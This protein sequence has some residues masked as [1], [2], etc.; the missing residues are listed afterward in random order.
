[1][2]SILLPDLGGGGAERIVVNL[3]NTWS[4]WGYKTEIVLMQHGGEFS[5]TVNPSVSVYCLNCPR[6]RTVPW[7]L[8]RYLMERRPNVLLANMWPLTSTAVLAWYLAGRRGK[9]FLCDHIALSEHV[10]RDLRVPLL[11]V[12]ALLRLSYPKA[13]GLIVVSKGVARD[14]ATISGLPEKSFK[15]IYNPVVEEG[16]H[17]YLHYQKSSAIQFLLWGGEFRVHV[18]TVG[19]LKAQKNH[20]MLLHAF[21]KVAVKL[22]AAL[23][24]LGEGDLRPILERDVEDLGLVGRVLMPGFHVDPSVWYRE[25]D[26]FVLTSDFEGFANVIAE[27]LA[28]GIP[29]LSTDCPYGPSEILDGRRYGELAPVGDA[30]AFASSIC[31]ALARRWDQRALQ[32]RALE[33]SIPKQAQLYLDL[34]NG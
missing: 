1:M 5:V 9:I 30:D 32:G 16:Q 15:V 27:A 8:T 6:I 29:T 20:R 2:I 28:W 25:A 11:G 23:V 26:L 7:A 22:D 31:I 13:T 33:F 19:S 4:S 10:K 18:L 21:S 17:P 12:K 14:I 3:A 24:I 34:F